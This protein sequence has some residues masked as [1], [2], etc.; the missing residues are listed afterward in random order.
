MS[1]PSGSS[2]RAFSPVGLFLHRPA[3]VWLATFATSRSPR[4]R[5]V[6]VLERGVRIG[7]PDVDGAVQTTGSSSVLLQPARMQSNA[8]ASRRSMVSL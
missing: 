2:M 4:V 3:P 6:G 8:T 7:V 5:D 1:S